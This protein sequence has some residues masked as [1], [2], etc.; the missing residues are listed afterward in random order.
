MT[1]LFYPMN[2]Q[3][4]GYFF[5]KKMLPFDNYVKVI[6]HTLYFSNN[7]AKQNWR[8]VWWNTKIKLVKERGPVLLCNH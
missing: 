4:T 8:C 2:K 5:F 1:L 6:S 3:I 7:H